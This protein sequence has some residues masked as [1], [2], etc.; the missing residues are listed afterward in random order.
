[1]SAFDPLR[2]LGSVEKPPLEPL[3]DEADRQSYRVGV[4]GSCAT[5]DNALAQVGS[6]ARCHSQNAETQR[7]HVS[8]IPEP[9]CNDE[10]DD[11]YD[12]AE[13]DVACWNQ[14]FVHAGKPISPDVRFPP[15]TVPCDCVA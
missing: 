14:P 8:D 5:V 10:D 12:L 13:E 4:N 2:T 6:C 11:Y 15:E 7:H 3:N 9:L 1:M